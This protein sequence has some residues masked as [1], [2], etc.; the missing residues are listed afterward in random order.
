MTQ[1]RIL[2]GTRSPATGRRYPI[3]TVLEVFA[4]PV[5]TFYARNSRS[6]APDSPAAPRAK[7]GPKTP[8]DDA[9][10]LSAI[11][12]VITTS[13]FSGEGYRKV[14]ARLAMRGLRVGRNRVHRLMKLHNLL[15]PTRHRHSGAKRIHD[16]TIITESPNQCWGGDAT[17]VVTTRDGKVT[18]FDLID[19]CTDEILGVT[20]TTTANRFAALDCLHQAVRREFGQVAKDTARGVTLRLDHGSQFTSG[21]YVN[22][23][24]HLGCSLSYAF[25]GQP[26]CNGVIERWHRTLK[27]QLLWTRTWETA[28]QVRAAVNEFVERYN[29][30][31]LIERHGHRPPRVVRN[32]F[33]T[34]EA[35]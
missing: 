11:R 21:R 29:H 18:I 20:V 30:H 13:P 31:W 28:D 33:R 34:T 5:S 14:R 3:R 4:L 10:L 24:T 8:L 15:A 9:A 6:A 12:G 23:A 19:H 2:I 27:E 7:S 35:A 1:A 17:E 26:E 22:E 32:G 16:G 25:V